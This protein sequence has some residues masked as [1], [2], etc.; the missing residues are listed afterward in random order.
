MVD[1]VFALEIF[2]ERPQSFLPH[3]RR[4]TNHTSNPAKPEIPAGRLLPV[5]G[6]DAVLLFRVQEAGLLPW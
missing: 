2:F 1:L 6:V 5:K 4:I 3:I